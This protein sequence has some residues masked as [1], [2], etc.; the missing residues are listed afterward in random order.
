M[1]VY[2]SVPQ[3]WYIAVCLSARRGGTGVPAPRRAGGG[4][5]AGGIHMPCSAWHAPSMRRTHRILSSAS[6][7]LET[8]SRRKISLLLHPPGNH[9]W[10]ED[11][12]SASRRGGLGLQ[13]H[14]AA[15]VHA[16]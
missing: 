13:H 10:A 2:G 7:A 4:A 9:R 1:Q 14:G 3:C 6:L 16:G 15:N 12:H 5:A 8:S 11:V